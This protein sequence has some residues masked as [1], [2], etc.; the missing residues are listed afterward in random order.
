MYRVKHTH[1]FRSV[2]AT[3][4]MYV[5]MYVCD[6]ERGSMTSTEY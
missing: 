1:S 6:E 2:G 3:E 5:C 4:G